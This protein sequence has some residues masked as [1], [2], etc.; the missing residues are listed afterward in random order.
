MTSVISSIASET[1]RLIATDST[2]ADQR[3]ITPEEYVELLASFS[4]NTLHL[5]PGPLKEF[6]DELRARKLMVCNV[7]EPDIRER[8]PKYFPDAI[9]GMADYFMIADSARKTGYAMTL[10]L[11]AAPIGLR[12]IV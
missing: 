2:S 10:S 8:Y 9:R 3:K 1:A 11:A 5:T 4:Q 7:N 6:L 12:R